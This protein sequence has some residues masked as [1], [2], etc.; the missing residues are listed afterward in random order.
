MNHEPE[1]T[2]CCIVGAG[3]AGMMLGLL[4]ARAGVHVTVLEKHS[5]FLRDFRGDTIHP[6]TIDLIEELGFLDDLEQLPH[7]IARR[8]RVDANGQW[9]EV[10]NLAAVRGRHRCIYMLP[11]WDFLELL[12]EKASECPTFVLR[13]RAEVTGVSMNEGR[14]AGVTYRTNG[15]TK[16]LTAD[17]TVACDGRSSTLRMLMG[18]RPIDLGAPMDVLW[19]RVPR[20]ADDP[21]E[22]FG[23]IRPGRMLVLIDRGTYWQAGYLIPKGEYETIRAKGIDQFRANLS[24]MVPRFADGRLTHLEDWD[25]DIRVLVVQ[26]NHLRRWY[27]PGLLVIGDAAHAMS[28]IGGVGINLALQDAVAAA[29]ILAGPLLRRRVTT[30]DLM[31]VQ[32]RRAPAA[33]LTQLLQLGVQQRLIRRVLGARSIRTPRFVAGLLGLRAVRALVARTIGTGVRP[34]RWRGANRSEAPH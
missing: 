19:F 1:A 6:S 10:A 11:Q 29:N 27:Y 17:L 23:V 26:V 4:L 13:K 25:R 3:P 8:L 31:R 28:P 12:A 24:E 32:A 30:F 34:E 22:T 14:V 5:D 18:A 16:R 2:T 21:D 9:L 15:E 20:H 33:M 7:R